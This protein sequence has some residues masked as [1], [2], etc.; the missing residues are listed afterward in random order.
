MRL[1]I[2]G[3]LC[4]I[5]ISFRR[6]KLPHLFPM[7]RSKI[8]QIY[9]NKL[10]VLLSTLQEVEGV[11]EAFTGG[12][13]GVMSIMFL[14]ELKKVQ[15]Q[16]L[17]GCP[18]CMGNGEILCGMCLGAGVLNFRSPNQCGCDICNGSGLVNCVNC[19]GDGRV[20]PIILQ[21]RAVRDPEY[22]TQ[23]SISID[24]P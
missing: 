22:A 16:R 23:N 1:L 4:N 7:S 18:Y 5:C 9:T 24:S 20:T 12:T 14:L 21:S 15:D 17:E 2:V 11:S 6:T 10:N 3:C 8:D 19:K 13:V